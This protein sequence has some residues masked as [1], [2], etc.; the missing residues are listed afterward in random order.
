LETIEELEV[1]FE[2]VWSG[3]RDYVIA[4]DLPEAVEKSLLKEYQPE[5]PPT[6]SDFEKAWEDDAE[7][8]DRLF[9][10]SHAI[11]QVKHSRLTIPAH[12]NLFSGDFAHQGRALLA[13]EAA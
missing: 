11:R 5:K 7:I 1:E 2:A 9:P 3:S 8:L 13:W 6:L 4:I 10:V 12:L